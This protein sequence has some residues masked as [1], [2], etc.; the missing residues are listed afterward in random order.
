[1]K[2]QSLIS[3]LILSVIMFV[4]VFAQAQVEA[5]KQLKSFKVKNGQYIAYESNIVDQQKSTLIL[6]PGINRG[7]DSRDEVIR[8][9]R[10]MKL[11][12]VSL[13]F[14]LHPE[15]LLMIPGNE[16]PAFKIQSISS[17]NLANEV[18]ALITGLKIY[19]PIIV[20]LSYSST[21]STELAKTGKYPLVIETAPMIRYDESDPQGAAVSDY[22]VKFFNLNPFLGPYL[23]SYFIKNTY[24]QYWDSK[25]PSILESYPETAPV[26]SLMVEAYTELSYA[27]HGFDFRK[28]KFNE[29][30]VRF[31]ILGENELE[32][33][34]AL[35]KEAVSLYQNSSSM[36]NAA[37]ILPNA[38]HIIPSDAPKAYLQIL[39]SF[40]D[41]Y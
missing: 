12:F 19:K 21:V 10:K 31:F 33:R 38:G 16:T 8:M 35:Q 15:S 9:A 22:W 30:V 34:L 36:K 40:T 14:S 26:K 7:L 3:G 23:S 13:H 18:D 20:S 5:V 29:N 24:S 32:G 4:S 6:L 1:M 37:V 2:K 11:N 25:L 17:A 39:K 28:Q 41:S 27:A